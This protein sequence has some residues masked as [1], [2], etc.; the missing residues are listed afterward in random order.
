MRK[1]GRQHR[2]N[3]RTEL[4]DMK[5]TM[6]YCERDT[7]SNLDLILGES[8]LKSSLNKVNTDF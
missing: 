7:S 5:D 8:S 1:A 4:L 3:P 6:I 2:I